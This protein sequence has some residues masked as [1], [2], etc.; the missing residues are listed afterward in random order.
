MRFFWQKFMPCCLF[1][2]EMLQ[3]FNTNTTQAPKTKILPKKSNINFLINFWSGNS[4]TSIA[5]LMGNFHKQSWE[6]RG[7]GRRGERGWRGLRDRKQL[8]AGIMGFW[9]GVV[10]LSPPLAPFRPPGWERMNSYI[11]ISAVRRAPSM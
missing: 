9:N 3:Y 10:R 7:V 11:L 6:S 4:V 5:T 2:T 8:R 1:Y